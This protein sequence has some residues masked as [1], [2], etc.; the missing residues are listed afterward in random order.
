[1]SEDYHRLA[2]LIHGN[3]PRP[4]ASPELTGNLMRVL[5]RKPDMWSQMADCRF[6]EGRFCSVAMVSKQTGLLVT[7]LITSGAEII[8]GVRGI[9]T[10]E[11]LLFFF[12]VICLS[13]VSPP[14]NVY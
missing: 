2:L 5:Q 3:W 4:L 14:T 1:M 9:K 13:I 6:Q 12:D 8:G 7:S 11:W 10:E